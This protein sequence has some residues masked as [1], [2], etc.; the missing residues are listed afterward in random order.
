MTTL[1]AYNVSWFL[2]LFSVIN[3]I[4]RY[5]WGKESIET[6][7][8]ITKCFPFTTL[9]RQIQGFLVS[10]PYL[11]STFDVALSIIN[12]RFSLRIALARHTNCL[13]P[14]LKFN[15][16]S[17]NSAFILPGRPSMASLSCTCRYRKKDF[18]LSKLLLKQTNL[19]DIRAL[20]SSGL[21]TH[22]A[23][24]TRVMG[25]ALSNEHSLRKMVES[26]KDRKISVS[27]IPATGYTP[28]TLPRD[29]LRKSLKK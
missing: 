23:C 29:Q 24:T 1:T 22:I 11:G 8:S 25:R 14:E 21:L 6:F 17:A 7:L 12:I 18:F 15:P 28:E 2:P 5:Q 20:M 26:T 9:T 27:S 4:K 10:A 19:L 3:I 16:V 13:C